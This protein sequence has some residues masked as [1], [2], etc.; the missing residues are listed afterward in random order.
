MQGPFRL[1]I[2]AAFQPQFASANARIALRYYRVADLYSFGL[3]TKRVQ[4]PSIGKVSDDLG[5]ARCCK[6]S[7]KDKMEIA[8]KSPPLCCKAGLGISLV[9]ERTGKTRQGLGILEGK[10]HVAGNHMR[11]RRRCGTG[12][13]NASFLS[14]NIAAFMRIRLDVEKV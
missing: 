2:D 13:R 8:N 14:Q 4:T 9:S 12:S 10:T 1:S 11:K 7:R 3:A 5:E 6:R